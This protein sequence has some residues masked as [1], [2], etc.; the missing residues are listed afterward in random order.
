MNFLVVEDSASDRELVEAAFAK[1][2][3]DATFTVVESAE[4]AE[5]H[6]RDKPLPSKTVILLDISLPGMSGVEFLRRF[7]QISFNTQYPVVV[8]SSSCSDSDIN[9]ALGAGANAYVVKPIGFNRLVELIDG[10]Y[11]FWEHHQFSCSDEEI[12]RASK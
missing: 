1:A 11:K 3:P 9:D 8:F 2:C 6:I 12:K 4:S 5:M 10:L 7:R